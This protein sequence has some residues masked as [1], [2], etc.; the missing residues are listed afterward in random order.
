MRVDSSGKIRIMSGA[1]SQGQG[2]ET[3]LAQVAADA[4]GISDGGHHGAHRR[5][6]RRSVRHRRLCKPSRRTRLKRREDRR[7]A[8]ARTYF[9][10]RRF[11]LGGRTGD[12]EIADGSVRV[13]G[14]PSQ[15]IRLG[16]LAVQTA[17]AFPGST[18]P[19]ELAE[20]GLETTA[21]FRPAQSTYASGYHVVTVEVDPVGGVVTILKYV[22][23]H[24]CGKRDQS[25][26]R[27]G[28]SPG[29]TRRGRRRSAVRAN[30]IR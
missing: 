6:G 26:D 13:V 19:N 21:Y 9:A 22:I 12:L 3:T 16:D 5:Y 17:G 25:A 27:R 8:A 29:R 18:L 15:S 20:I 11:V 2:H 1:A 10:S 4:L 7:D 30:G 24:D 23:S 28:T 14:S